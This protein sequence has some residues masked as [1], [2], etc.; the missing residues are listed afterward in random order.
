MAQEMDG[1]ASCPRCARLGRL[2]SM[3]S[4]Q[5]ALRPER[6]A[7]IGDVAELAGSD[8]RAHASR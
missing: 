7:P 1:E 2:V 5:M 4:T 6:E 8:F 3:Y